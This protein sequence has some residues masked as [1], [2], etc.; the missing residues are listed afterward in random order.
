MIGQ[1]AERAKCTVA[2]VCTNV[3]QMACTNVPSTYLRYN[4]FI[5]DIIIRNKFSWSWWFKIKQPVCDSVYLQMCV[6][7]KFPFFS[8]SS[9]VPTYLKC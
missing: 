1:M 7:F 2:G 4:V 5:K 9:S 3:G 6:I 8:N